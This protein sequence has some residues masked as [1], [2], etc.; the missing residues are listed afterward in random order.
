MEQAKI[1]DTIRIIALAPFN[2]KHDPAE[3][4]YVGK[5]GVITFIDGTGMLHGTWGGIGIL[6]QDSF[7][8]VK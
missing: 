4:N 6:P 2:G 5:T 1:G 7:E 3:S 8:I